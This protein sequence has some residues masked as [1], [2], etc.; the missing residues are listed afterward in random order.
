LLTEFASYGQYFN[1]C[2]QKKKIFSMKLYCIAAGVYLPEGLHP[3]IPFF[4]YSIIPV[5]SEA[6]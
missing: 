6:N 1:A 4:Q 2:G 5:V 3:I